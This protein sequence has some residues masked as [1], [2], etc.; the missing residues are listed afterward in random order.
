MTDGKR[1][2]AYWELDNLDQ[3]GRL[4]DIGPSPGP[5]AEDLLR[6]WRRRGR[7]ARLIRRAAFLSVIAVCV[8]LLVAFWLWQQPGN[9]WSLSTVKQLVMNYGAFATSFATVL[10]TFGLLAATWRYANLTASMLEE[11]RAGHR[12]EAEPQVTM[13]VWPWLE[14][15]KDPKSVF[16]YITHVVVRNVGRVPILDLSLRDLMAPLQTGFSSGAGNIGPGD[17]VTTLLPGSE[18]TTFWGC[19]QQ[20]IDEWRE[21]RHP[22]RRAF[23][24]L[25]L[26]YRDSWNRPCSVT[27]DYELGA[28]EKPPFRITLKC[29]FVAT[30]TTP[31]WR[32]ATGRDGLWISA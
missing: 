11:M 24:T 9:I 32:Q 29:E 2:A 8:S 23:V 1:Y 4:V 16:D 7:R 28:S 27:Q 25:R 6:I 14:V 22:S 18:T 19:M 15:E 3:D 26:R 17:I 21:R 5:S 30:P 20:E 10:L 31:R 12:Y 13:S